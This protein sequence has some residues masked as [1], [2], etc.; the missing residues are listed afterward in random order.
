MDRLKYFANKMCI[1]SKLRYI[2]LILCLSLISFIIIYQMYYINYS[3]NGG[4]TKS[5]PHESPMQS[6]M[7]KDRKFSTDNIL[8]QQS[9]FIF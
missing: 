4:N 8:K 5:T 7:N 3:W 1:H 6:F 9:L 2:L